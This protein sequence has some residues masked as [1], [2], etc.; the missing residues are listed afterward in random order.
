MIQY[1]GLI[2]TVYLSLIFLGFFFLMNLLGISH[3]SKD[4]NHKC[5]CDWLL[6][7]HISALPSNKIHIYVYIF[8]F[9]TKNQY[10]LYIYMYI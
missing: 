1:S 8:M 5:Q 9:I 6:R 4:Y 2:S 10:I 3:L 7:I